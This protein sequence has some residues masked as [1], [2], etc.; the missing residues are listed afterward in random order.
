MLSILEQFLYLSFKITKKHTSILKLKTPENA[1]VMLHGNLVQVSASKQ[2]SEC[3]KEAQEYHMSSFEFYN[4]HVFSFSGKDFRYSR[5]VKADAYALSCFFN[6][7][8]LNLGK[9]TKSKTPKPRKYSESSNF[10][11]LYIAEHDYVWTSSRV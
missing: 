6:S 7:P 2:M 1:K 4:L 5:H 10:F 8:R 11:F 3:C 9:H